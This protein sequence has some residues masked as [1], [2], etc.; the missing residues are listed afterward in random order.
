MKTE[1]QNDSIN[2]IIHE[3]RRNMV[4]LFVFGGMIVFVYSRALE[5]FG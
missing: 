2:E 5:A 3:C 1:N 4:R